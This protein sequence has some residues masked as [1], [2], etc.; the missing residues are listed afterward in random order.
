VSIFNRFL[1]P[2][3]L[4]LMLSLAGIGA[5]VFAQIEGGERGVAPIDS[6]S[7]FEVTGVKVDVAANSADVARLGGWREAQRRGW[8]MLWAKIHGGGAP[9]LSDSMLDSIVSGIVVEE[10]QIGPKRYIA[11]LGVLFDRVRTGQILGVTGLATR[12]APLL[13][14]PVQWSGGTAQSFE[15]RT[16][17]QKA[18]ARYKTAGSAIDY[19]RPSGTGADPLLLN[20]AQTGRPGR[21]WWRMLLDQYGAADVLMPQVRLTRLWPGGPVIGNF[22]AR[23]GPDNRLLGNFTLRVESSAKMAE[24]MD[25]GVRRM[26]QM[27]AGALAAGQLRPDSS[28]VIE[29]P[30]VP[31]DIAVAVE[32]VPTLE[33]AN[34]DDAPEIAAPVIEVS[35]Y[36]VQYDSPDVGSISS[37]ESA[38]RGVPGVKSATTGSLALG[39][40]SV[41]RVAFAGDV[42]TLKLALSARGFKVQEGGGVLRISR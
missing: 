6:S 30:V 1:R 39:G 29:E 18:W 3:P 41:M 11:T 16:E 2:V 10:E 23:Y 17:W 24:L 36:T 28:L 34:P 21:K 15:T 38:V 14:I 31:E 19:V 13:V 37:T 7:D 8:R 42:A 35:T 33:T 25:E 12:S 40:V 20:F 9:G 26:D 32:E 5:V 22:T 27:Y 4:A